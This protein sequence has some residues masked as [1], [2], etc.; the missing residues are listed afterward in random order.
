MPQTPI[1]RSTTQPAQRQPT[2]APRHAPDQAPPATLTPGGA[3]GVHAERAVPWTFRQTLLGAALTLLP[4]LAVALTLA[5]TPQTAAGQSSHRL[6]LSLDVAT[7]A[8]IFVASAALEGVFALA[9]FYYA[10]RAAPSTGEAAPTGDDAETGARRARLRR[11]AQRLGLM[12]WQT[13]PA[14]MRASASDWPRWW[15]RRWPTL[16]LTLALAALTLAAS[17]LYSYL[18]AL[19][20]SPIGTNSD[21]LAQQAQTAPLTT[22]G[23]LLAAIIVAPICEELFF[24]GFLFRGLLCGMSLWPAILVSSLLFAVAH[25]DLGSFIPLLLIGIALAYARWRS[26]SLW[27]SVAIHTINNLVAALFILPT[28]ITALGK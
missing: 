21:A 10:L 2:T 22:L 1:R 14:T 19:T 27:P 20:H 18:L 16:W 23:A 4:W 25:T 26:R 12:G 15:P 9:P 13:Q 3:D 24:R 5:A 6:A 17:A 11:A 28:I 7:G 8:F